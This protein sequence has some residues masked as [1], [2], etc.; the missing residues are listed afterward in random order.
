VIAVVA[1]LVVAALDCWQWR[2]NGIG[3]V[4]G[5]TVGGL[6]GGLVAST[7]G[8]ALGHVD[9]VTATAGLAPGATLEA[10][11]KLRATGVLLLWPLASLLVVMAVGA[12][13]GLD[14][15]PVETVDDPAP[16]AEDVVPRAAPGDAVPPP[17]G[18]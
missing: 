15:D 13:Y 4:I 3:V 16:G 8:Q 11:L 14:D 10:G 1:G 7:V 18:P 12:S 5:V 6:L 2:R 17:P 9:L